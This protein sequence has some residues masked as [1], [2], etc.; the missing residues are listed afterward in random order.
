MQQVIMDVGKI[1]VQVGLVTMKQAIRL[2]SWN[3]EMKYM[4]AINVNIWII[5]IYVYS[6]RTVQIYRVF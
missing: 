5:H 1:S 3:D 2:R 6:G 4:N